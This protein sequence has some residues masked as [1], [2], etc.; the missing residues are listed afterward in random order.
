MF[1]GIYI[2]LYSI[3]IHV[4]YA[5]IIDAVNNLKCETCQLRECC[6]EDKTIIGAMLTHTLLHHR[7]VCRYLDV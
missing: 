5:L 7:L 2:Q 6:D 3:E 4:S 1:F